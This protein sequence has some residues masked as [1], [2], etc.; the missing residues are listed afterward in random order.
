MVI[1]SLV[2][3][4][5]V[6]THFYVNIGAFISFLLNYFFR[7]LAHPKNWSIYVPDCSVGHFLS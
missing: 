6:N 3:F 7:S 2:P 4:H 1:V 5:E